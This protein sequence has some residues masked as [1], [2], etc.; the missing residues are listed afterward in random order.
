RGRDAAGLAPGKAALACVAPPEGASAVE[1]SVRGD[2]VDKGGEASFAAE[3]VAVAV[4]VE[5]GLL[6]HVFGLAVAPEH[7]HQKAK[8]APLVPLH[9]RLEGRGVATAPARH[10]FPV[11]I[12]E[13][14]GP[15]HPR[16]D[17]GSSFCDLV[18]HFSPHWLQTPSG[19]I[20]FPRP[21][22]AQRARPT[23]PSPR[24]SYVPLFPPLLRTSRTLSRVMPRSTDLHMS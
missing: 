20:R 6:R 15:H 1:R 2:A 13:H 18:A 21:R 11:G 16:P 7:P 10:E 23:R 5:E 19:R 8:D 14:R 22:P 3:T 24:R 17:E 4:Q 9:E 12:F